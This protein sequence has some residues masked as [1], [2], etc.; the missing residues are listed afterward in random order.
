MSSPH[1]STCDAALYQRDGGRHASLV[2]TALAATVVLTMVPA[3][4]G[5]LP[6][7][8]PFGAFR[9]PA[10]VAQTEAVKNSEVGPEW[11]IPPGQEELLAEMLG[12]GATLP[13][14]C[15]FAG[16]EA[17]R[18]VITTTYTCAQE[19]VAFELR[20]P[21]AAPPGAT[22]TGRFAIALHHGTP[23]KDLTEALVALIRSRE[24]G[25]QWKRIGPLSR[26]SARGT[27][28]VT[29]AALLGAAVLGW[30]LLRRRRP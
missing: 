21:S 8:D 9:V 2:Q 22:Q 12:R 20:H 29:A 17:N 10:A 23:Q 28:L 19:E 1:A 30:T 7:T 24:G 11:V 3:A 18:T 13:G 5:L 27:V 26:P 4:F 6:A 16:A 14:D 15:K 25:F